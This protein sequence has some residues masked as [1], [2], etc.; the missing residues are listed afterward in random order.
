MVYKFY[1]HKMIWVKIVA[2]VNLQ[3][4]FLRQYSVLVQK[5]WFINHNYWIFY[6]ISK[7]WDTEGAK[8]RGAPTENKICLFEN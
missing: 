6:E 8:A 1:K 3:Q 2:V 5:M 4:R 7:L